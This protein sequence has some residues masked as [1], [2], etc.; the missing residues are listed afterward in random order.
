MEKKYQRR[1]GWVVI[2]SVVLIGIAI[3]ND[4]LLY[5]AMVI[6]HRHQPAL[7]SRIAAHLRHRPTGARLAL[8]DI[9][10]RWGRTEGLASWM[11]VTTPLQI[12][13]DLEQ[14]AK[15]TDLLLIRR[16]EAL[17]IL[18]ERRHVTADLVQWY[19]LVKDGR[20]E[21][22][23]LMFLSRRDLYN[24]LQAIGVDDSVFP[25]PEG[26]DAVITPVDEFEAIVGK[27][28]K[29]T[30]RQHGPEEEKCLIPTREQFQ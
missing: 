5:K 27:A 19:N 14:I 17:R 25:W 3:C 9:G 1:L 24:C 7:A 6:F 12:D 20:S 16:T 10:H 23:G 8:L 11:L 18:W 4:H 13:P 22:D 30:Q 15:N 28:A 29:R 26:D 2:I 21:H